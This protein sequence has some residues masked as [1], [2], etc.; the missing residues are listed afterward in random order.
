MFPSSAARFPSRVRFHQ[1]HATAEAA[2]VKTRSRPTLIAVTVMVAFG[3]LVEA[4]C[5]RGQAAEAGSDTQQRGSDVVAVQNEVRR[6]DGDA[7]HKLLADLTA[8]ENAYA[9]HTD[10]TEFDRDLATAFRRYGLDLDQVEPKVAGERLGGRASTSEIAGAL[11]EW[12]RVRRMQPNTPD[13][14]RLAEVAR[15]ADPDP[16]R[17]SLRDQYERPTA[18]ARPALRRLAAD[19]GALEKQPAASLM[20]L[21]LLLKEAGDQSN[22]R[23]V[24]RAAT[25]RFPSHFS[26]WLELGNLNSSAAEESPDPAEAARC[27]AQAVA[28]RPGSHAA[29]TSL[30]IA[31]ANQGK[32]DEATREFL[33]AERL[34]KDSNVTLTDVKQLDLAVAKV[35][36]E[37]GQ[38]PARASEQPDLGEAP[39]AKEVAAAVFGRGPVAGQSEPQSPAGFYNRGISY[40]QKKEYSKA[41][42]DFDK[43]IK[44]DPKFASAYV[45]RA[46]IWLMKKDFD[47]AIADYNEALRLDHQNNA[48]RGRGFALLGKKQTA[49]AIDDFNE[50]ICIAPEDA[51]AYYG[52]GHAWTARKEAEK[53]IVDFDEAIRL[54]PLF[55][56]AH[57]ARG[58]ALSSQ[59][60]FDKAIAD[61]DDAA[62]LDPNGANAYT[63]RG[64]AWSQKKDYEKAIADYDEA[65]RLD[66]EDAGALNGRAWLWSTSTEA[67]Y[68]NGKQAVETAKKAC[69]LTEYKDAMI[70][71]TLAAASAE[72]GDFDSA[73]K[74]QTKAIESITDDKDRDDFRARLALYQQKKP[75]RQSATD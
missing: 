69:E 53:A 35:E 54:D 65:I 20:T 4:R 36:S 24:L 38:E 19:A 26:L 2:L 16:W 50:A 72:T 57:V 11:D 49:K 6:P 25:R 42:S 40:A 17:N 45:V 59:K 13:W 10:P 68:R 14:R 28:L 73:V 74:W 27:F 22:A 64:Y 32:I 29:H 5:A 1:H 70:I 66:P 37:Q 46:E 71:D 3:T 43:V 18:E 15:A 7:E 75:Y 12:C 30:G 8:A 44:L 21:A 41:I 67:K 23:S 39:D 62:R 61:F 58:H 33:E 63:G 48:Y 51:I 34:K 9:D 31:M 55:S 47:H 60:E 52:R 56:A